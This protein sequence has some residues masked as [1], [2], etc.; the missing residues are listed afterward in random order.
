MVAAEGSGEAISA[1]ST[2]CPA[3]DAREG[4]VLG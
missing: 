4:R 3:D 1:A 2:C